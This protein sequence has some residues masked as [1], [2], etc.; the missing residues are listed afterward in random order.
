MNPPRALIGRGPVRHARR[1]PVARA[2]RYDTWFLLL[3]MRTLR[4]QP[5]PVLARNRAAR[6]S[7]H[8]CDHGDGGDD[9][10]AWFE[11][12]LAAEGITD[13]DGEIWLHTYPRVLGYAFKPVSFWYAHRADG[14]LRAIVAEVNN[15]FG[16]R[17]CYLLD[18]PAWGRELRADKVFHV[19]PFC[20]VEGR[21]RFRFLRT[22]E[23]TVV[24][25]DHD[26]ADGRELISTSVSGHLEPLTA[27][28]LHRAWTAH[29]LLTLGV[30]ARIHWQALQLWW[31]RVPFFHKPVP[32]AALVSR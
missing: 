25:I 22:P 1:R 12:L 21:Y 14:A 9:A 32:P 15:T 23:R 10:L 27:E 30:M 16:E 11:R 4:Q 3:P 31:R 17:H 28:A 24:R 8:D 20:R 29:P 19:S 13:A 6:V 18:R 26:D 2:F 7:F 5:D